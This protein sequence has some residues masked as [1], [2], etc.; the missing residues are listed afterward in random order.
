[1]PELAAR[2]RAEQSIAE[3]RKP[4]HRGQMNFARTDGRLAGLAA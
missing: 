3:L 4:V 1:M 2:V